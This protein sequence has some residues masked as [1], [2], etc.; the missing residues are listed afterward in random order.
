MASVSNFSK[1]DAN[2]QEFSYPER[3]N[4][5]ANL[6]LNSAPKALDVENTFSDYSNTLKLENEE[7]VCYQFSHE[8]TVLSLYSLANADMGR[9]IAVHFPDRVLNLHHTFTIREVNDEIIVE[10]ILKDGLYLILHFPL[11]CVLDGASAI[12]ENWF[13]VLNPYDFTV[14]QPQYAYPVDYNFTVVFLEDGGLLGLTRSR[15]KQGSYEVTPTLFNDN[16]YLQSLTKIL[17][18]GRRASHYTNVV[19]CTVY[20]K[21]FLITL[22]QN[23]SMKIWDLHKQAVIVERALAIDEKHKNKVYETLGQYLTLHEDQLAIF[24]PFENGM[25]QIWDFRLDS[26]GDLLVSP[27]S[28]YSSNLSSCSIWSLVDMKFTKAVDLGSVPGFINLVVL[29]RSNRIMKLQV[30]KVI[31]ENLKDYEWLEATNH[32]LMDMKADLNILTNG[33]TEQAL[34]NI[35]AH[36]TSSIFTRA[37]RILSESGV[38][39]SPESPYNHEYL[40]NLESVLKDLKKRSDEPSSLTLFQDEIIMVNSLSLYSHSLYKIDSELESIFYNLNEESSLG[41]SLGDYLRIIE[42]FASTLS[43]QVLSNVSDAFI[44]VMTSSFPS[45]VSFKEKFTQIFLQH[46]E[47]R[48]HMANLKKLYDGLSRL[49]V[50]SILNKFID[51]HL[52]KPHLEQTLVDSLIPNS[53]ANVALLQSAH[54]AILIQKDLVL[55][56][57]LIFVFLDFDYSVL[58]PQIKTLLALH[59]K[60]CL[61]VRLYQLDKKLLAAEMLAR[62]SKY[63]NGYR[64]KTYADWTLSLTAILNEVYS[65]AV[66][67]NPLFIEA[68]DSFI[69][70]GTRSSKLCHSFL[71]TV[72]QR[73]YIHTNVAHEFMLG[74]SFFMCGI[75]DRAFEFLQKHPYPEALPQELPDSLYMPLQKDGHLWCDVVSSFKLASIQGLRLLF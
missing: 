49:D 19:S 32:S 40:L 72:Q 14:R 33:D 55:K 28:V 43:N 69:L 66:S 23:C 67:P 73:F 52:Q 24:L 75:Y 1:I 3:A 31:S 30:L 53:V 61:W 15:N 44:D 65:M 10:V 38:L 16:S 68:F 7:Y 62:T 36:Y 26:D 60:Q 35:K 27:G 9:T 25:F 54:Q 4:K 39:L 37:Q 59:Y 51:D 71:K 8:Y 41:G 18:S 56:V 45:E 46:L 34:M 64:I 13:T 29:W 22:T 2:L 20:R 58:Q 6:F 17:F 57:L 74:L 42:G 21:R 47:G 70:S 11:N 12:P 50:V 63:G 48:F 5:V